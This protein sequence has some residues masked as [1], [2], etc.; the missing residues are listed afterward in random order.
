MG[1]ELAPLRPLERREE[2]LRTLRIPQK[3]GGL[4][5]RVVIVFRD[6]HGVAM[7]RDNLHGYVIGVDPLNEAE[8]VSP[9]LAC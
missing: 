5:H 6:E 3:I 1:G 7:F 8:Q 9:C 4:D 2:P